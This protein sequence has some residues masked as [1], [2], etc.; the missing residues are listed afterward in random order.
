MPTYSDICSDYTEDITRYPGSVRRQLGALYEY[1]LSISQSGHRSPFDEPVPNVPK[2]MFVVASAAVIEDQVQFPFPGK[3]DFFTEFTSGSLVLK[4]LS[5]NTTLFK[6]TVNG[7]N[8]GGATG[9]STFTSKGTL[10]RNKLLISGQFINFD[11][12]IVVAGERTAPESVSV[13]CILTFLGDMELPLFLSVPKAPFIQGYPGGD[14]VPIP[15][16]PIDPW[17]DGPSGWFD[18]DDLPADQRPPYWL[19]PGEG[20]DHT[21][22]SVSPRRLKIRQWGFAMDGRSIDSNTKRDA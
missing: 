14:I 15:G 19:S 9:T 1:I 3:R 21:L 5:T 2:K 17:P 4:A 7:E 6:T 10:Q 8:P 18:S 16:V 13:C 20:E 11:K 22:P 12:M